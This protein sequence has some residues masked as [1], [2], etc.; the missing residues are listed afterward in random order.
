MED[1]Y[2]EL[3]MLYSDEVGGDNIPLEWLEFCPYV[4][5]ERDAD[6]KITIILTKPP[7][8]K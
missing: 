1:S 8:K 7:E 2:Q 5:M 3:M 4:G 6:G